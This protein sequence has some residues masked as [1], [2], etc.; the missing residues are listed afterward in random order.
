MGQ[1][2]KTQLD[3]DELLTSVWLQIINRRQPCSIPAIMCTWCCNVNKCF[4]TCFYAQLR[5]S[6][7]PL[8][9]STLMVTLYRKKNKTKPRMDSYQAHFKIFST[10]ADCVFNFNQQDLT[11]YLILRDFA[12]SQLLEQLLSNYILI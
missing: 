6:F 12:C 3:S 2:G 4:L 1:L 9:Q 5:H 11:Y 10:Y 7:S 8:P